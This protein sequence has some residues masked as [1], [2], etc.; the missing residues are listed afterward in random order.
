MTVLISQ[1]DT[2]KV[3]STLFA[4]NARVAILR[5]F[6]L[7]PLRA[8]YQR[9]LEQATGL[10]IRA[11]QRELER[12]VSIGL[13]FR[14]AEGNRTYHQVDMDFPLFPELHN[15][16]LKTSSE[17][18][19]L[20]G[21]LAMNPA[22]RLA[23]LS[24]SEGRLL[25][26][27]KPGQTL[28]ALEAAPYAVEAIGSDTFLVWLGEKNE[29]LHPFLVEGMDMLGRREDVIWRR[30]EANGYSVTKGEGIP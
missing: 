25:V 18:D 22:V 24:P 14:H 28:T 15:L 12:L 16:I 5:I 30:I 27:T 10:A 3:L 6:M 7:D 11:V 26:V 17:F 9:Q 21:R 2:E 8:Y 1:I 19:R 29:A 20:R 4:S 13:L 23:F